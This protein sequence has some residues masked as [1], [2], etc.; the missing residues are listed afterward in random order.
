MPNALMFAMQLLGQLPALIAGG[1]D[2]IGLVTDANDALKKMKAEKRDPTPEEW[3]A[4]NA[5][6]DELRGQLHSA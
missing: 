6:I 1:H 3:G 2:V 5:K 4:L